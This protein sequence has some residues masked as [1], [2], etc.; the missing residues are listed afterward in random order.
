[1]DLLSI[2]SAQHKAKI[3]STA[4]WHVLLTVI[5]DPVNDPGTLLRLVRSPDDVVYQG[6][7]YY[8]FSFEFD[9][10][11]DKSSGELQSVQLQVANVNRVVQGYLNQY[12]GAAGAEIRIAVVSAEDMSGPPA[13]LYIF[14]VQ[15]SSADAIWV[16]FTLGGANPMMRQF[17]R[18][19]YL[20]AQCPWIY[21]A[22]ALQATADPRGAA[23][24]YWG[25]LASCN[26]T[27]ADCQNHNN[28]VRFGGY[29]AVSTQGFA[30]VGPA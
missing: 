29:P 19:L 27:Y 18:Y 7:T 30:S 23:C 1:M 6:D 28:L 14:G 2:A 16:T 12:N 26:H 9:V 4:P 15:S 8:A 21:N 24:G 11:W 3:A 5:P 13:Q 22:P 10:I 20:A 17:L 25:P